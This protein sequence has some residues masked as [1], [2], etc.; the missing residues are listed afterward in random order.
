MQFF[1][2]FCFLIL[3]S[4]SVFSD[5][6]PISYY[7]KN[8]KKRSLSSSSQKKKRLLDRFSIPKEKSRKPTSA[9]EAN[10]NKYFRTDIL[11]DDFHTPL[12][13]DK[14]H[15]A[16]K[17]YVG[18]IESACHA[19]MTKSEKLKM[20]TD[21]LQHLRA[22]TG[23]TL[24]QY[25]LKL[26]DR[27][28]LLNIFEHTDPKHIPYSKK[29]RSDTDFFCKQIKNEFNSYYLYS[30]NLPKKIKLNEYPH[31]WVSSILKSLNCTCE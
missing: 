5:K 14:V 12:S 11:G 21:N 3:F 28:D 31:E 8:V 26:Y 29:N 16:I 10:D 17:Q 20:V 18:A 15:F 6:D 2:S 4:N 19:K 30:Y 22:Y 27:V 24:E 25:N 23:H 1:L 13:S 7:K 9:A